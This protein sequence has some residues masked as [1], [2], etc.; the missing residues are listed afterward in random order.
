M[1][2]TY[3]FGML[4]L[5]PTDCKAIHIS[6][7]GVVD[8]ASN[9]QSNSDGSGCGDGS[10]IGFSRTGARRAE[11]RRPTACAGAAASCRTRASGTMTCV[12]EEF[13]FSLPDPLAGPPGAR[14]ADHSA[15]A[16]KEWVA[17]AIVDAADEHPRLLPRRDRRHG[18]PRRRR[19]RLCVLGQGGSQ[20]EPKVDPQ[21]GPLSRRA[22]PQGRRHRLPAAGD[23]LDRRRRVPG[24][25][26]REHH[27]GRRRDRHDQG[28]RARRGAH[29][30]VHRRR[31]RPD[32]QLEAGQRGCWPD[33]RWA[34]AGRP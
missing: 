26:R 1:G 8:S 17:G 11:R 19:R 15:P 32:L 33:Q 6:G 2:S 20:A 22:R 10:N 12:V 4:A 7:T 3:P 21:P 28:R 13:S 31:R 23:L 14:Q 34:A 29:A 30:A 16:M 18:I 24:V 9:V 5:S 25:E 27:L